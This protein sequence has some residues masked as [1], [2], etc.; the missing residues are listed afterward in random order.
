ML[1]CPVG[2]EAVASLRKLQ[3]VEKDNADNEVELNLQEMVSVVH[4]SSVGVFL[5]KARQLMWLKVQR[6]HFW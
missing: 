5:P 4:P 3:A 2:T 6:T 1:V